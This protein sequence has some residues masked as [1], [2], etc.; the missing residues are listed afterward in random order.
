MNRPLILAHFLIECL[1]VALKTV[2]IDEKGIST[3]DLLSQFDFIRFEYVDK[4][5]F[6]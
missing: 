3:V 5:F 6:T 4:N 1:A 2:F